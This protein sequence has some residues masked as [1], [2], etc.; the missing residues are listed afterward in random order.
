MIKFILL[1]I[2]VIVAAQVCPDTQDTYNNKCID[3][4]CWDRVGRIQSLT[5]TNPT[6]VLNIRPWFETLLIDGKND[7]ILNNIRF[8]DN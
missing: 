5:N 7:R 1:S 6:D 4:T 3:P 2:L 8:S